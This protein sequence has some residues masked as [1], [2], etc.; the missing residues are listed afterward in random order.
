MIIVLSGIVTYG[1]SNITQNS[2]VTQGTQN[3]VD[4]FIYN[5][6]HDVAGSMTDI[7]M[8]RIAND[9][10]YRVV[11][12][13]SEPLF[14]GE[15]TYVVE[16]TFFDND[17]LIKITVTGKFNDITKNVITYTQKPTDGWVPPF[18][19]GAW[20]ANGD[21]N[22]TI[23]DMYIDGRDHDLNLNIIPTTGVHGVSSSTNFINKDGAEIGGTNSFIDYP[24]AF[25]HSP[26][27]IEENYNW[28]GSFPETPDEILGYPEGTLKA[29]AQSGEYGSQY[30]L[31]PPN[32]KKIDGDL[33]TYPLSGVTYVEVQN[34]SDIAVVIEQTGNSGIFV[35]HR[36]NGDSHISSIKADKDSDGLLTGLLITDVSFHHHI[37]ILGAVLMLSTDLVTNKNC[38]GNQDHW[39]YYSSEAVVGATHI[40]A[41]IT[42]LSQQVGYGF[43][44]KR[45]KVRYVYE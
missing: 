15:A 19:R 33:L 22:N 8:M 25:P 6:A 21:L 42:G 30:L 23:S 40:A 32:K 9:L 2:T 41:E 7:L 34:A 38:S 3:V 5:R 44:K 28:G 13:K 17:S 20:T 37:D 4:N 11:T 36:D 27:V 26:E 16:D 24:M 31:L 35:I 18:I 10:E 14:G 12:K 45:V 29:A 39:V 1:I 43:G